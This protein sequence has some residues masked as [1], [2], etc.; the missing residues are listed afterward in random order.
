MLTSAVLETSV[1]TGCHPSGLVPPKAS[2]DGDVNGLLAAPP[3]HTRQAR[4]H[5]GECDS[6]F[7]L[8]SSVATNDCNVFNVC[9]V[10]NVCSVCTVCIVVPE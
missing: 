1:A 5:S 8:A 6:F 7:S 4:G 2:D 9:N 3:S 10:C